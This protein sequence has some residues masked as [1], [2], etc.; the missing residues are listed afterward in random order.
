MCLSYTTPGFPGGMVKKLRSFAIRR[1]VS[2]LSN[3]L[4]S[5]AVRSKLFLAYRC[6]NT[7]HVQ[8]PP[9]QYNTCTSTI[10]TIQKCTSIIVTIQNMQKNH[11]DNTK[12]VQ[13]PLLQYQTC[14]STTMTIQIMYKNHLLQYKTC[15]S[16]TITMQDMYKYHYDNTKHVQVPL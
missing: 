7:K 9:S 2:G 11:Y 16:T 14:T 15:T 10:V 1:R 3:S 6:Q 12:H 8:I 13:V 4:T 5:K